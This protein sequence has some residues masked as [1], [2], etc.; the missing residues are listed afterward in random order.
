MLDPCPIRSFLKLMYL[1]DSV[2]KIHLSFSLP[3]G[4]FCC[5]ERDTSDLSFKLSVNK[6][7]DCL[8]AFSDAHLICSFL[9]ICL[10]GYWMQGSAKRL[11]KAALQEA[12]RKREMRYSDLRKIDKKVRRHF[13]D[14]I[15]VIVL[16]FNHDLISR[17]NVH[18]DQPL[19][20]RSAFDH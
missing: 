15:S 10:I 3:L 11:V 8:Q 12:A 7:F 13:H 17:N 5:G 6:H 4:C 2:I 9:A 14:D 16:F 1:L 20:V 19:S 18:L